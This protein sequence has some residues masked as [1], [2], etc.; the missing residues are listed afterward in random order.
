V[1]LCE[2]FVEFVTAG[3]IWKKLLPENFQGASSGSWP[4]GMRRQAPQSS[5]LGLGEER[6]SNI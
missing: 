2:Q 1:C 6:I 4:P 5:Q 3:E